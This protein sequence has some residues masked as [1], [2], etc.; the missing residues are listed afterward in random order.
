MNIKFP[1]SLQNSSSP[2][3]K[4]ASFNIILKIST[5]TKNCRAFELKCTAIFIAG[6]L[7][8]VAKKTGK[9][10][11]N[12]IDRQQITTTGQTLEQKKSIENYPHIEKKVIMSTKMYSKMKSTAKHAKKMFVELKI[13]VFMMFR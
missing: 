3:E 12:K 6:T 4:T 7:I 13:Y 1:Q 2:Q 10:Y 8:E 5:R 11:K 9:K